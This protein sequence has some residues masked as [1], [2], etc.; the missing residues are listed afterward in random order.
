MSGIGPAT[1]ADIAALITV[2]LVAPPVTAPATATS[3]VSA[4]TTPSSDIAQSGGVG[5][6]PDYLPIPRLRIVTHAPREVIAGADTVFSARVFDENGRLRDDAR[7]SWVFGDGREQKGASVYHIFYESGEYA[8]SVFATTEYGGEAEAEFTITARTA[9]VSIIANDARGITVAHTGTT[10]LDLSRWRLR[11]GAGGE[12]VIPERTRILANKSVTF[13]PQVTGLS[14]S[15]AALL[16]YPSGEVA[17][18][19]PGP[20]TKPLAGTERSNKVQ[21]VETVTKIS[22]K[23]YEEP[24]VL[25]P[26]T[27]ALAAVAGAPVQTSSTSLLISPWTLSFALVVLA[28]AAALRFSR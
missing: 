15:P 3:T 27:T 4:S 13:A 14:P 25:A 21:R 9:G 16:V 7:V 22:P 12:F 28:G 24:A 26:T 1:Y 17:A 20:A 5:G 6:E 8:V 19:Y 2:G 11:G 10:A 23:A 18:I